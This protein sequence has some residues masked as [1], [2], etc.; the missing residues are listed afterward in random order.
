MIIFFFLIIKLFERLGAFCA[1]R[2][3][4]PRKPHHTGVK[5]WGMC[6]EN[7]FLFSFF[8]YAG[9]ETRSVDTLPLGQDVVVRFEKLLPPGKFF[10]KNMKKI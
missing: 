1:I 10:L 7:N 3:H 6:D 8:I 2:Q 9:K 5:F 4:V